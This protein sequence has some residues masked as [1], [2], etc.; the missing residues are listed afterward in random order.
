MLQQVIKMMLPIIYQTFVRM[1][2]MGVWVLK[3]VYEHKEIIH[4]YITCFF[5]SDDG[6]NKK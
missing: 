5:F 2:D 6:T 3:N 1:A 4:I